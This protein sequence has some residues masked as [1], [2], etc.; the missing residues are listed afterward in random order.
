MVSERGHR[1]YTSRAHEDNRLPRRRTASAS[2]P[3]AF[4]DGDKLL[5]DEIENLLPE[6][7]APATEAPRAFAFEEMLACEACLRANPPTRMNCLYCGEKLPAAE[8]RAAHLRPTLRPLEE[9]ERGLNVILLP[10]E[11]E[12]SPESLAE[13]AKFLRTDDER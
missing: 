1:D 8:T 2:A 6:E 7:F 10:C 9:W 11:R 4:E 3:L 12:P 5:A 13:A